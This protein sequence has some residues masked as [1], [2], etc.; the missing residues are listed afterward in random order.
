MEIRIIQFGVTCTRYK[1][2]LFGNTGKE[3]RLSDMEFDSKERAI[4]CAK[5]WQIVLSCEINHYREVVT[6]TIKLECLTK[7]EIK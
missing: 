3:K 7:E 5:E 4:R 1:V 6:T 2:V